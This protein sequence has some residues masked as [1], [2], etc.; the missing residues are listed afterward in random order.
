MKYVL[1]AFALFWLAAIYSTVLADLRGPDY[2]LAPPGAEQPARTIIAVGP[3]LAAQGVAP[4]AILDLPRVS[5]A[6]RVRILGV[7]P[8]GTSIALPISSHGTLRTVVVPA[9][10]ARGKSTWWI[11]AFDLI[12]NTFALG[13]AG[14]LGYRKPGIMIAALILYLGG[15]D[16]SWPAFTGLFS[17]LPDDA[18]AALARTLCALCSWFPVLALASF[19]VRFPGDERSAVQKSLVRVVDAIVVAGFLIAFLPVFDLGLRNDAAIAGNALSAVVVVAASL[20]SLRS[21]PKSSRGRVGVVFIAVMIGGAGYAINMIVYQFTHNFTPFYLYTTLAVLTV[22]TAVAYAILRHRIFDVSF[23]LNRT[24]VYGVT[25]AFVLVVF[26]AL[27]FV[28]ERYLS[29]LTRFE[30]IAVEFAIALALIVSVRLVHGRVDRLVDGVL[31]RARHEQES[32]LRRYA[33]TVQFYTAQAPLVRDTLDALVRFGRVRGANAYIVSGAG[34]VCVGSSHDTTPPDV[35]ENDPTYVEMRAHMERLQI[36]DAHT[37]FRGDRLY[38][39]V[40]AGRLVGVL[41]TGERDS[42]ESMPPDIDDAIASIASAVAISLAA[43]ETTQ[44]RAENAALQAR[45]ATAG[46]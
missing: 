28:A 11:S 15:G 8:A 20:I 46:A 14:F 42:G 17:W 1:P 13:I 22:P 6:Q 35:D 7:V 24:L 16:L 32:A 26:A 33:T 44:V 43:I 41:A 29:N 30:G 10:I 34:L 39:L 27:E 21:A 25:S 12:V 18:Y 3:D 45:L 37:A 19:A 36:N 38:P 2:R 40:L 9:T 5:Y 4:G 31:F 23:V